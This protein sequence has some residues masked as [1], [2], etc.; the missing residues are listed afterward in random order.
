MAYRNPECCTPA[1]FNKTVWITVNPGISPL[2]AYLLLIFLDGG[3]FE[4]RA[5]SRGAYKI[6][7]IKF[8]TFCIKSL[9]SKTP[10]N[11]LKFCHGGLLEGTNSR[12]Y[13]M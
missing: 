7:Y 8:D 5:Y 12:I 13:G 10:I 2:E 4:G 9:L 1:L 11:N 3:I 6:R